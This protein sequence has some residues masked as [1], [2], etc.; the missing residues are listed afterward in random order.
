MATPITIDTTLISGIISAA[1]AIIV[2]CGTVIWTTV[3]NRRLEKTKLLQA[4]RE[5]V[6]SLCEDMNEIIS[7]KHFDSEGDSHI[8]SSATVSKAMDEIR[9]I[10]SIEIKTNKIKTIN[11]IYFPEMKKCCERMTRNIVSFYSSVASMTAINSIFDSKEPRKHYDTLMID[12]RY[13]DA[14]NS[15]KEYKENI[16][17]L[18]I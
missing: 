8:T 10:A 11:S 1:V 13:K 16:I 5:E 9:S 4:K 2:A 12:E 18:K 17:S 3:S 15:I 14:K 6:L 7:L